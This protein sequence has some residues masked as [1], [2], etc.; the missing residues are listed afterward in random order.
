VARFLAS[1][2][3]YVY[4]QSGDSLYVNLFV[5]GSTRVEVAGE[6]VE[7]RQTTDYPWS[8]DVTIA[9]EPAAETELTLHV[10]IPGWARGRPV[11][12]ELYRYADEA[13]QAWALSV[14]GEPT[15]V[16]LVN[17]YAALRR[18]WKPGDSVT[19]SLPMP[20]RRVVSHERVAANAGR[21]ALERGPI[22]YALEAIDNGGQVFNVVLPDD[23]ALA[24]EHRPELLGGVTVITGKALGLY[25]APDGR[26]VETREQDFTAVPYN[27]WSNRGEDPMT[28]WMPRRVS[29]DFDVP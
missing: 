3:E 1:F 5:A 13:E 10:R 2:G 17:G 7:L 29:L 22:V 6:A 14:N 16:E 25:A 27:V 8:G 20:V 9:V 12:S 11:P 4:S 18:R 23:A 21:V 26:S 24:S 28:V 19:L 15:E